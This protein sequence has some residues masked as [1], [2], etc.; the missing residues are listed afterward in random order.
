LGP[1]ERKAIHD[2][3]GLLG[4]EHISLGF[5]A[6]RLHVSQP[7]LFHYNGQIHEKVVLRAGSLYLESP[8]LDEIAHKYGAPLPALY[9][10]Q[11]EKRTDLIITLL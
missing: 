3:A 8:F 4:L 10:E 5:P 1:A 2:A 7:K 11:R 9:R 6:R